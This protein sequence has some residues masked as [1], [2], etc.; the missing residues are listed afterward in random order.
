MNLSD[1]ERWNA[2][3]QIFQA[4]LLNDAHIVWRRTTKFGRITHVGMGSDA[5]TQG[6]G[7]LCA[8]QFWG[9]FLLMPTPFDANYQ[10]WRDNTYGDGLVLGVSHAPTALGRGPSAPQFWGFPS[11]YAY[12]LCSRTTK[13]DVE[14][15]CKTPCISGS[16]TAHIPK[17]GVPT[18]HSFG[19]SPVLYLHPLTQNDEIRHC[20]TYGE[21]RGLGGQP[22]HCICTNV[23]RVCQRQLSYL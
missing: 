5:P 12:T 8:L 20:N 18:I 7:V 16:A 9:F 21:G 17:S 4:V 23:S 15:A 22:G 19:G 11:V 2:M 13:F 3:G 10:I 1:P 6:D 14:G